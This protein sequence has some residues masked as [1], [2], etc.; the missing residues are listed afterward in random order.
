MIVLNIAWMKLKSYG[1]YPSNWVLLVMMPLLL[2]VIMGFAL[3]DLYGSTKK[4]SLDIA[5]DSGGF[6]DFYLQ[7]KEIEIPGVNIHL[8]DNR[9]YDVLVSI[10]EKTKRISIMADS[11]Q[12]SEI[13]KS[14]LES[15]NLKTSL[16]D[17]SSFDIDNS[18]TN[19]RSLSSSRTPEAVDYFGVTILVMFLLYSAH[20]SADGLINEK[21]IGTLQRISVSPA[22]NYSIL[23]GISL[24]A[25][26]ASIIQS[27]IIIYVAS[28]IFGVY[29][30]NNLFLLGIVLLSV[31]L[32][33]VS[34]GIWIGAL[35]ICNKEN[36]G[37]IINISILFMCF[38]GGSWIPIPETGFFS[39]LCKISP[40]YWFNKIVLAV[41]Y[42]GNSSTVLLV[43]LIFIGL[44]IVMLTHGSWKF[45][46]KE[47]K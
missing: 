5:I 20:F 39:I 14:I 24:S 7:M 22:Q 12:I 21:R 10:D 3:S 16:E 44:S 6:S 1:R 11:I 23:A 34:F 45:L 37:G 17:L 36:I 32:V 8:M 2:I 30:G 19:I 29:Y 15:L 26:T 43:I 41:I 42:G 31:I 28:K 13:A 35:F 38:L 46:S 9:E 40:V 25:I 4:I 33:V 27:V 47:L 18:Y